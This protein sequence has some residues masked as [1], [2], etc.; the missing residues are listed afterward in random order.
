MTMKTQILVIAE[1][2]LAA[3]GCRKFHLDEMGDHLCTSTTHSGAKKAH[4]WVVEQLADLF[5]TTHTV[6]TQHVTKSR[7]RHCGDIQLATYLANAAG[8]V[9]L[10]LDLH[11]DHD[12][13]GSISATSLNGN[14]HYPNDIDK[15]LH[16]DTTDKI[17]K[18]RTD[19][20]H[21]PPIAVSFMTAI[22]STSGRLHSEF[23]RLL[24]LQTH[25][26][27]HHT[28][29]CV[30]NSPHNRTCGAPVVNLRLELVPRMP[31]VRTVVW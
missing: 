17:R 19:Y 24:F 25:R 1:K 2:S 6:K 7:G 5:R 12:R 28:C 20:N 18:Y 22:S 4:D 11:I 27:P 15:S 3:C 26:E 16:D 10:V 14:L 30:V 8:P 31:H 21:N 23:I 9:P 29:G 13:F